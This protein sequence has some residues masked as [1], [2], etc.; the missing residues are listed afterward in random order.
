MICLHIHID[1]SVSNKYNLIENK[2]IYFFFTLFKQWVHWIC[3]DTRSLNFYF[4]FI[5]KEEEEDK[6]IMD[7]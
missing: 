5:E 3:W 7:I 2:C 1:N 4:Y 6:T